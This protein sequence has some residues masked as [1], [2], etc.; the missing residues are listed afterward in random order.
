M[1]KYFLHQLMMKNFFIQRLLT[2][3]LT[4]CITYTCH[5]NVYVFKNTNKR[6]Y[7]KDYDGFFFWKTFRFVYVLPIQPEVE[8]TIVNDQTQFFQLDFRE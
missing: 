6:I 4:K 2:K 1:M 5:K 7:L 3:S 8:E